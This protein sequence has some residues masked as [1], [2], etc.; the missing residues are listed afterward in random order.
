VETDNALTE[1]GLQ[2]RVGDAV[3]VH[4]PHRLAALVADAEPFLRAA[5]AHVHHVLVDR[6]VG[7]LYKWALTVVER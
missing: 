1:Q 4:E 5:A 2:L 3:C 6:S 7:H